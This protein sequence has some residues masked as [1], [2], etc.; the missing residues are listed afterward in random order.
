M[1]FSIFL[2]QFSIE[3]LS[4]FTIPW[5]PWRHRRWLSYGWK[6][7]AQLPSSSWLPVSYPINLYRCWEWRHAC[8]SKT[9]SPICFSILTRYK[10]QIPPNGKP[11]FKGCLLL[12]KFLWNCGPKQRI[13]SLRVAMDYNVKKA[14]IFFSKGDAKVQGIY[15]EHDL[16]IQSLQGFWAPIWG[17]PIAENQLG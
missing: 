10:F 9:T 8:N 16:I 4:I 12:V 15:P 5:F 6:H 13:S 14:W 17:T 11:V 3:S 2:V 7:L 1:L